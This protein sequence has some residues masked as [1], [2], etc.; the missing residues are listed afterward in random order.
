[1]D[2]IQCRHWSGAGAFLDKAV[3]Q[4][5]VLSLISAMTMAHVSYITKLVWGT[6]QGP[7]EF[8]EGITSIL[9]T[10]YLNLDTVLIVLG[11]TAFSKSLPG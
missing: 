5:W 10:A 6:R 1:M 3:V 2:V 9:L 4:Y 7:R 8:C 11:L